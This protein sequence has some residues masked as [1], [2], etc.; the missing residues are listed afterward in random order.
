MTNAHHL[1][2]RSPATFAGESLTVRVFMRQQQKGSKL[3]SS[4][5]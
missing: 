3:Q 2:K 1:N 4:G 5:C